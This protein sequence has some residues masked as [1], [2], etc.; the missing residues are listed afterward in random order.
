M[1]LW[2]HAAID[3]RQKKPEV[4]KSK[5]A[6]SLALVV[7]EEWET[8]LSEQCPLHYTDS[9]M[10]GETNSCAKEHLRASPIIFKTVDKS[11]IFCKS[12]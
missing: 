8:Y 11:M 9:E 4:V 1:W 3:T 6:T 5:N 2:F 12:I 7:L 10:L